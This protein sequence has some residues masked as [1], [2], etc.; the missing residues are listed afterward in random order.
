MRKLNLST[1]FPHQKIRWNY[2]ILDTEYSHHNRENLLLPLQMQISLKQEG[3]AGLLLIFENWIKFWVFSKK[4]T[5]I[6]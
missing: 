1:K 6:A 2:G 5:M 3:F 4:K